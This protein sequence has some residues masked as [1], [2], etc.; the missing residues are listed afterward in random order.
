[1]QIAF[2]AKLKMDRQEAN[3]LAKEQRKATATATK[4][5]ERASKDARL[6]ASFRA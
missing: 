4:K 5:A 3:K 2:K 1:M 6:K